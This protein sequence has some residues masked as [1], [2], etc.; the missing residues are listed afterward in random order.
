MNLDLLLDETT[1]GA[2]DAA[3]LLRAIA[4]CGEYGR[5]AAELDGA[6]DARAIAADAATFDAAT[7]D[8]LQDALRR[9][10]DVAPALARAGVGD[11]LDDAAFLELLRFCDAWLR[12]RATLTRHDRELGTAAA[13]AACISLVSL[14]A[15]GRAGTYGFYLDERF[16]PILGAARA[17]AQRAQAEFDAARGRS[18]QGI[19]QAL[20][21]DEIGEYE[22]ILMR[23]DAPSPLPE[24]LRVVREAPTYLLCECELDERALAAL[25]RRDEADAALAQVERDVR[26]ALSA[27]VRERMAGLEDAAAAFGALDAHV[28]KVRFAQTYACVAAEEA[29]AGISFEDARYLPLLDQLAHEGRAY[30]PISLDLPGVAILTGPNMGGKSIALRT[31]GFLALC[32]A[33]GLPVPAKRARIERFERISWLGIAPESESGGLLSSFAREVVRLRAILERPHERTVV[34]VDE[35][36]RTTTPQEGRALLIALVARLRERDAT[37]LIATHLAGIAQASGATH[38][39]IRGLRGVPARPAGG[40]LS[41]ALA[42]LAGAMDYTLAEVTADSPPQADALALARL[43]G[44]DEALVAAAYAALG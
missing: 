23:A 39:A 9:A 30:A 2:L 5:R 37:A 22:F 32:V 14:L 34:L 28:A 20:G 8:A 12:A 13:A 38:Y 42:A 10:P 15:H 41:A 16:D 1:A 7:L 19:A 4:P 26:E 21:R 33:L 3:W 18:T 29:A 24:G 17:R 11:A 40:D 43:L 31:C 36:A 27:R 25:A 6:P 35:F 44:L